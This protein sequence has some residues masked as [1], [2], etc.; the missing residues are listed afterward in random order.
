MRC[1]SR[2]DRAHGLFQRNG[3]QRRKQLHA[4]S[5]Q[6]VAG[7]VQSDALAKGWP[8]AGLLRFQGQISPLSDIALQAAGSAQKTSCLG[9]HPVL[10][11]VPVDVELRLKGGVAFPEP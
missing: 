4:V 8:R 2:L 10:G 3:C 6:C 7:H 1:V 9:K 5:A 11:Y